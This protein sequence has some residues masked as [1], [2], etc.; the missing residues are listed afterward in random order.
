MTGSFLYRDNVELFIFNFL[1]DKNSFVHSPRSKKH[2]VSSWPLHSSVVAFRT[3]LTFHFE[4]DS[5]GMRTFILFLLG[6]L[7]ACY[8][9]SETTPGILRGFDTQQALRLETRDHEHELSKGRHCRPRNIH[10]SPTGS[11]GSVRVT[12][13]TSKIGC[14]SEVYYKRKHW[15]KSSIRYSSWPRLSLRCTFTRCKK[16]GKEKVFDDVL[17]CWRGNETDWTPKSIMYRH[18]AVLNNLLPGRVEYK[19]WFVSGDPGSE[20]EFHS[21]QINGFDSA[22]RF[23]AFGD[24]GAPTARKCPGAR[25]TINTLTGEV[26]E[27]DLI[28]HNGDIAYA[29]GSNDIWDDFQQAI[30][31]I[32]S[33]VPYAVAV[34]NHEYDWI[35]GSEFKR[36]SRVV[37]AS[38]LLQPYLPEWGNF[39]ADSRGECGYPLINRFVMPN[40]IHSKTP[41]HAPFWY[42]VKTGP[43]HFI[44]LSSE[45]NITAG[46][47][48]RKWLE[49]EFES[50]DRSKSPW[51]IVL[52]HRPLYVAFPHKSNRIVG[53]HLTTI[54]EEEFIKQHVNLVI[55]G[56][57]HS[58]YRTCPLLRGSCNKNGIVY[59]TIGSA[60]KQI[61]DLDDREDQPPWMANAQTLHGYGR[62]HIRSPS[63]LSFE[64]VETE[65]GSAHVIDAVKIHNNNDMV[66]K[67]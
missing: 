31:P 58:Y 53:E 55:S 16:I 44:I 13:Q 22:L 6:F 35:P 28:F 29:D 23:V 24:M 21:P 62:F 4:N 43:A 52:I 49:D 32:S 19:Y 46:S 38:G 27:I 7:N 50:V 36:T 34:G 5:D 65:S 64:Y 56:H 59:M 39:G 54:L 41:S 30:E 60:G 26:G 61:S 3:P 42:S 2:R 11:D 20:Y 14:S 63:E 10:L 57:V 40:S 47:R 15:F 51:L 8:G 33:S 67:S 66:H 45:H 18:S 48:Q 37:D 9:L 1:F 17:D 25:G 12:W